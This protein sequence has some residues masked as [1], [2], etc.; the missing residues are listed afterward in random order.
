[1]TDLP[2]EGYLAP[3][4]R[5]FARMILARQ[6]TH[7]TPAILRLERNYGPVGISYMA[8]GLATLLPF[9]WIGMAGIVLVFATHGSRFAY[10]L[11]GV[12]AVGVLPSLIRLRQGAEAGRQHRQGRP[13][14]RRGRP[15][16]R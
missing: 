6:E 14:E 7:R 3:H 15:E 16:P 11:L 10:V 13:F 5:W 2:V 12:G 1:M 8:A 9:Q 4:E